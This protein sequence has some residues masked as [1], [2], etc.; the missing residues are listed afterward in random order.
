MKKISIIMKF[1]SICLVTISICLV[2]EVKAD[3]GFDSNWGSDSGYDPNG[4]TYSGP[5]YS[6]PS[7]GS[8]YNGNGSGGENKPLSP[9]AIIGFISLGVGIVGFGSLAIFGN[10]IPFLKRID[11]KRE[12][13]RE[14]KKLAKIGLDHS[15]EINNDKIAGII[16]QEFDKNQFIQDRYNDFVNIQLGWMNFDYD[17]LSI[18]LGNELYNQYKTQLEHMKALNRQ[19]IM[20][21]FEFIDAMITKFEKEGQTLIV[22]I[23]LITQFYDYLEENNKKITGNS[24]HKERIHYELTFMC[25][26]VESDFL[27]NKWILIFKEAKNGA[28]VLNNE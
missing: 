1:I 27:R 20:S 2:L 23:E 19:N 21:D 22:K 18:K 16:N 11:E 25:N 9:G 8:T 24:E 14:N 7:G 6:G 12:I 17:L 3:S 4:S 13:N 26:N 10:K 15:K 28:K 5:Y